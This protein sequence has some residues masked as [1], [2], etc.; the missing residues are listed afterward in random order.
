MS[1]TFDKAKLITTV[2]AAVK[3]AD[4]ADEKYQAELATYRAEREALLPDYL[5][6][7]RALR[8]ELSKVIKRGKQPTQTDARAFRAAAGEDY[9][10]HLYLTPV[11]DREARNNV[12]TPRGWIN[13]N[14][15]ESYRG[16]VAMLEANTEDTI[17]ANQLKLFGYTDM[18]ALFRLAAHNGAV[19]E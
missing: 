18:E 9:L 6:R 8:D 2:K 19:I 7:L 11:S 10:S 14:R 17:T 13:A 1:I 16:L 12:S 15:R 4:T 5:T 3:A